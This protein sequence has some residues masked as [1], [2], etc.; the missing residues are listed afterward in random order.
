[1]Q[2]PDHITNS[3]EAPPPAEPMR[4]FPDWR[5]V[6]KHEIAALEKRVAE[7]EHNQAKFAVAFN[8]HSERIGA[9]KEF[10]GN[11]PAPMTSGIQSG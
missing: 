4:E 3:A 1:M 8:E 10:A 5:A 6:H 11:F 2:H 7:L 9:L